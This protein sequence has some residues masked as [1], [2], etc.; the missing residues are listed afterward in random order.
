MR[1]VVP[2]VLVALTACGA[3]TS[4]GQTTT[5]SARVEAR[6]REVVPPSPPPRMGQMMNSYTPLPTLPEESATIPE[7]AS[8]PPGTSV[9]TVPATIA[10]R[11]RRITESLRKAIAA[12]DTLSPTAKSVEV[13]T[14]DRKV[15]LK[16][17]ALN[18]QERMNIDTKAR[19]A[20]DVIEVDDQIELVPNAP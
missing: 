15:I 9:V 13:I 3:S 10:Q 8:P 14:K 11:D 1:I 5:T 6:R 12:D 17:R 2:I 18:E 20:D 16:G 19:A 4:N 7:T